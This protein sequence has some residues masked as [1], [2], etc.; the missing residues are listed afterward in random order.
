[1]LKRTFGAETNIIGTETDFFIKKGFYIGCRER[2]KKWFRKR[3]PKLVNTEREHAQSFPLP[4]SKRAAHAL[5]LP[6]YSAIFFSGTI[7][8][9]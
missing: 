4:L 9:A 8:K 2:K 1:M 7:K 6:S 5:N 3:G